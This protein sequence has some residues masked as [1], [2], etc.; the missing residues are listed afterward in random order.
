[1]AL[2]PTVQ[3]LR[4]EDFCEFKASLIYRASSRIVKAIQRNLVSKQTNKTK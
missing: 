2:I 4:Q 1:M 3:R